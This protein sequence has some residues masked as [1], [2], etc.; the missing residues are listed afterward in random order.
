MCKNELLDYYRK[1]D[2]NK[3]KKVFLVH[4]ELDQQEMLRDSLKELNICKVDIPVRS[5]IKEV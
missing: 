1:F 3:L 2:E 4:G 5:E